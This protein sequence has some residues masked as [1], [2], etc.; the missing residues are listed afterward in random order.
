MSHQ[1][2]R[3]PAAALRRFFGVPFRAQTY[4]NLAYLLLAFPLGLLYFVGL[5]AG[6][7]AGL[8]L[9]V[10]LV[11]IPLLVLTVAAAAG[12]AGFEAKLATWLLGVEATPPAALGELDDS[13]DSS[14]ALLDATTWTGLLLVALKFVF[15]LVALVA[16]VTAG[17]LAAS[18]LFAPLLYDAAGVTYNTGPYVVDTLA[19][20]LAASGVGVLVTLVSLH[21]LN[22][23]AKLGGFTTAAL[24]GDEVEPPADG[25]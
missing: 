12:A 13:L 18:L 21:V 4:R 24:L 10:T 1:S 19:E 25:G 9:A 16:V 3:G 11:G 14:E 5:S 7:S 17:A 20:A 8:G 22:G 15:G 23:L 2:K 6:L